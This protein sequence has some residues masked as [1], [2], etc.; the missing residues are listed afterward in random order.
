MI[1]STST[2]MELSHFTRYGFTKV[3]TQHFPPG[4][5]SPSASATNLSTTENEGKEDEASATTLGK[6]HPEIEN[7]FN[8]ISRK[9]TEDRIDQFISMF[10]GSWCSIGIDKTNLK[11]ML[12]TKCLKSH[13]KEYLLR[14]GGKVQ[15]CFFESNIYIASRTKL[16]NLKLEDKT[17]LNGYIDYQKTRRRPFGMK[18]EV[19]DKEQK[20]TVIYNNKVKGPDN[21]SLSFLDAVDLICKGYSTDDGKIAPAALIMLSYDQY[22]VSTNIGG[23]DQYLSNIFEDHRWV[24][25][26]IFTAARTTFLRFSNTTLESPKKSLI[27]RNR[28]MLNNPHTCRPYSAFVITSNNKSFPYAPVTTFLPPHENKGILSG[29][30]LKDKTTTII[31]LRGEALDS[32][33]MTHLNNFTWKP[34]ENM[35]PLQKQYFEIPR[36]WL[37]T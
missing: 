13:H 1:P 23:I 27:T 17:T 37:G 29:I 11:S 18:F 8:Q 31:V 16:C 2:N 35:T 7:A 6:E 22:R 12:A 5:T 28:I 36:S 19:C 26:E 10:H 21:K 9:V 30:N 15:I 4:Y 34:F 25:S 32:L 20:V 3:Y 33:N 24:N 14:R